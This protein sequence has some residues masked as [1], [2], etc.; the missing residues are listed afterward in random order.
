MAA[1]RFA[2]STK[3]KADPLIVKAAHSW[4]KRLVGLLGSSHLALNDGLWIKP[5][6]GIHT[7]GMLYKIDV[8]F[9]DQG[10]R[11]TK[12][13]RNI[14]PFWF[15]MAPKGTESVIELASG[16]AARYGFE[17]D[18]QLQISRLK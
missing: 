18:Q 9:L 11:I 12:I 17:L 7:I 14:P 1:E 8:I 10:L 4:L 3:N 5:C 15:S 2:I 6:K 16:A 13:H